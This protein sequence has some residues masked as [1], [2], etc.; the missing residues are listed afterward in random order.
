MKK[1]L[2]TAALSTLS[3]SAFAA[4]PKMSFSGEQAELLFEALNLKTTYTS[5]GLLKEVTGVRCEKILPLYRPMD[6]DV[7]RNR[8][9]LDRRRPGGP[10]I[11]TCDIQENMTNRELEMVYINLDL[12]EEGRRGYGNTYTKRVSSKL[13]FTKHTSLR[14]YGT[15]TYSMEQSI[16]EPRPEFDTVVVRGPK[17]RRLFK[18]LDT[19]INYTVRG[20]LSIETKT[21]GPLTCEKTFNPYSR[22]LRGPKFSCSMQGRLQ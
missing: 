2:M 18:K 4:N 13:S 12:R 7:V 8:R 16:V 22:D 10:G 6:G 21:V 15:T 9:D 20:M 3:L 14:P 1:L 19:E 5:S 11:F 17:A